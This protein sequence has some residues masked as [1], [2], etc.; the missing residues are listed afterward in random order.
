[1]IYLVNSTDGPTEADEQFTDLQNATDRAR[2]LSE[3][4]A[5]FPFAV[6]NNNEN[7]D[8]L[9]LAYGGEVFTKA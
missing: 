1:M 8:C 9:V 3:G 5:V 6:W 4:D 7:G 2:E